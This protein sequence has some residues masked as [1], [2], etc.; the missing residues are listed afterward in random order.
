MAVKTVQYVSQ[1]D[2]GA[3]QLAQNVLKD[4]QARFDQTYAGLIN[5]YARQGDVFSLDT[6]FKEKQMNQLKGRV[7]EVVDK[8]NGDYGAASKDLARLIAEERQNPF[9]NLNKLH[10]QKKAEEMALKKIW[11]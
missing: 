1:F 2:P 9:Y 5:E 4:K 6:E 11:S 3:E 7:D 10:I 8:Y